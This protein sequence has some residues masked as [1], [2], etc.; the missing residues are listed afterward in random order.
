MYVAEA[1]CQQ[2]KQRLSDWLAAAVA[3]IE[4][5]YDLTHKCDWMIESLRIKHWYSDNHF[6]LV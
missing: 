5:F 4:M 6:I 1:Q 3:V 2:P